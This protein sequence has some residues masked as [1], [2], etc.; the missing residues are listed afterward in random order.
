MTKELRTFGLLLYKNL[1]VRKKHWK[2]TIFLQCLIP[3]SLFILIQ[4]I[5]DF[6]VQPPLVFN[7]STYYPIQTKQ[8]LT[9]LN[10]E[11]TQLYY[12]PQNS[13]TENILEDVRMC[14]KLSHEN[15]AGF[16]TENDMIN[17][18]TMLQAKSPTTDVLALVFEQYNT[19]DI[20]YKIRHSFKIPNIL[21]Q[22]MFDQP[23]YN[24]HTIYLNT[25]P[26]VQLQICVD[27]TFI[28]HV[29][30]QSMMDIKVLYTCI[31]IINI[32]IF[33]ILFITFILVVNT[34][35]ALSSTCQNR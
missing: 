14:L 8:K 23:H 20:R 24:A 27:E 9:L 25:I 15:V 4:A 30:S 34:K 1:I 12:V 3:I 11:F 21:F 33:F 16:L 26:F 10:R 29:A 7:E 22:N 17:A 32:N 28:Q 6:S 19:T 13:Y 18:Y 31:V 2:T 35:N 5:R